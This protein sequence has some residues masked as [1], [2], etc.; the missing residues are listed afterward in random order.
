MVKICFKQKNKEDRIIIET[1]LNSRVTELVMSSEFVKKNK[2][3]KNKLEKLIYVRN[4]NSIFN[5]EKPIEYIVEV[6][7]FYMRYKERIKINIIR[8]QKW[9]MILG[10]P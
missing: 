2:F 10:M 5:Q 7:L 8:G 3:K 9:N 6:K 1:L 4:V